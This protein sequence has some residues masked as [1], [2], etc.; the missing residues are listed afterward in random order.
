MQVKIAFE[1]KDERTRKKHTYWH[2]THTK[3]T[4]LDLFFFINL[5]KMFLGIMSEVM[6]VVGLAGTVGGDESPA[7]EFKRPA[8]VT[9]SCGE[10]SHGRTLRDKG[11][12]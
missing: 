10:G 2:F 11:K 12:R 6:M 5:S 3:V 7:R 1:G 9:R 4:Y 8:G